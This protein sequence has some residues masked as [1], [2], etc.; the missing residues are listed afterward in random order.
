MKTQEEDQVPSSSSSNE[1]SKHLLSNGI[2]TIDD[3]RKRELKEKFLR[4]AK[5]AVANAKPKKGNLHQLLASYVP[6][7]LR[8]PKQLTSEPSCELLTGVVLFTGTCLACQLIL[9]KIHNKMIIVTVLDISGF[10]KLTE[11]LTKRGPEGVEALTNVL[12]TYF[13]QLIHIVNSFDGGK[14]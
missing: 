1:E 14:L 7:L 2:K 4:A 13:G 10:T 6:Q 3:E 5:K 12:N 9:R 11:K 8:V